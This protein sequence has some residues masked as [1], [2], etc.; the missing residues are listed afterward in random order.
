[1]FEDVRE[2][3]K[4]G[5]SGSPAAARSTI[6]VDSAIAAK[7]LNPSCSAGAGACAHGGITG[8]DKGI[9]RRVFSAMSLLPPLRLSHTCPFVPACSPPR[10]PLLG[11]VPAPS[12]YTRAVFT[13]LHLP[14]RALSPA[15]PRRALCRTVSAPSHRFHALAP[16]LHCR[17]VVVPLS[18]RRCARALLT[19]SFPPASLAPSSSPSE[20]VVV[21]AR[22]CA[23]RTLLAPSRPSRPK[24]PSRP[25]VGLV[26]PRS[27]RR[28]PFV[29][30]P[31][32]PSRAAVAPALHRAVSPVA[33]FSRP[34]HRV[35]AVLPL[36][37]SRPLR[38]PCRPL[39]VPLSRLTRAVTLL[40]LCSRHCRAVAPLCR[41]PSR[42]PSRDRACLALAHPFVVP[43]L[44]LVRTTLASMCLCPPVR[45][46]PH[47]LFPS[48]CS[49]ASCLFCAC[50]I[51]AC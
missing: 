17:T 14:R 24:L 34:S 19:P 5:K 40:A 20:A 33:R 31:L 39:F 8:D 21:P 1:M 15:L 48:P 45:R 10:P 44:A 27:H 18:R 36:A 6:G 32:C 47:A 11:F 25:V 2:M 16:S 35:R 30:P 29:T 43:C 7:D 22:R 38:V 50:L 46:A 51:P 4:S 12:S 23:P 41:P 3:D 49:P 42:A 9:G 37:P 13:P 26:A 28:R